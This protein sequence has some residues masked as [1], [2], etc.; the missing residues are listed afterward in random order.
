MNTQW[1]R[2]AASAITLLG[3][4]T[5]AF[6]A[7]EAQSGGLFRA[8]ISP[9][10]SDYHGQWHVALAELPDGRV[11]ATWEAGHTETKTP[12]VILSSSSSDG[13]RTWGKA[14][15]FYRRDGVR[16]TTNGFFWLDEQLHFVYTELP[17]PGRKEKC[18]IVQ[19][20]STDGGHS[21]Q[22]P[23]EIWVIEDGEDG[24]AMRPVVLE[25]KRVALPF[26]YSK[27]TPKGPGAR[28][29]RVLL[30]TD[31]AQTWT[32]T[33]SI[34]CDIPPGPMEPALAEC[35]GGD[36]L[37]VLRTRGTGKVYASR[38]AD[39]GQSWTKAVATALESPE[40]IARLLRLHDDSL[41]LVWNG[42][43]SKAQG[44]RNP[45]TAARSYDGGRTW[46]ERRDLV[47]TPGG[48]LYSNH[49]VVQLRNGTVLVGYQDLHS[50]SKIKTTRG[51]VDS[52][53]LVGFDL[54]WLSGGKQAAK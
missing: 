19:R 5:G 1:I 33:A 15:E 9:E 28:L 24:E 22:A 34:P 46:P 11:L 48:G 42:V 8:T 25:D 49:G 16:C 29:S 17:L 40:S 31:G 45:L 4:A 23:R 54:E 26:Y 10:S 39:A 47:Y 18:R 50:N 38:S 36:W 3:C 44:P 51:G 43:E 30:S 14:E 13:G 35:P 6:A 20:V 2:T 53:E 32:E 12:N 41:L 37:C 27:T 52:V 21:W 7:E